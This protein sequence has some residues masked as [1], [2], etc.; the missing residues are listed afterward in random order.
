[1]STVLT[2]SEAERLIALEKHTANREPIAYPNLGGSVRAELIAD[3]GREAFFLDV[4]RGSVVF[5]KTTNQL[6]ARHSIILLRLDLGGAPHRNPDGAEI[7]C[8]HLHVYRENFAVKWAF[9]VPEELS[10]DLSNFK[11]TLFDFMTYCRIIEQP[12]FIFGLPFS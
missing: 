5:S 6:R 11:V 2:Q 9:P 4:R 7:P 8:P 10:K 12:K 3:E 1:M